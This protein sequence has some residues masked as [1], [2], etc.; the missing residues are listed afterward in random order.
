VL[1]AFPSS[2]FASDHCR[3]VCRHFFSSV[4]VNHVLLLELYCAIDDVELS[5]LV[6]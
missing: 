3:R 6:L 5:V 4:H 1:V 2:C